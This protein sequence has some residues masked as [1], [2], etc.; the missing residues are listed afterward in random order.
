MT[1]DAHLKIVCNTGSSMN[2]MQYVIGCD[3]IHTMIN[4][5]QITLWCRV[6]VSRELRK[7]FIAAHNG[8]PSWLTKAYV[9]T[10]HDVEGHNFLNH[11]VVTDELHDIHPREWT[12]QTLITVEEATEVY[13]VGVLANCHCW[14][15]QLICCRFWTW[16]LVWKGKE[17][18]YSWNS[19][20]C[21]WH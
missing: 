20:T 1:Q 12:N 15:R 18:V 3:Y 7:Q 9:C 4:S 6:G 21:A 10:V 16:L 11:G 13:M 14:K 19:P 17:V 8:K 5:H 2:T